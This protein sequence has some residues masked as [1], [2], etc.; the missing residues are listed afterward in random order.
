MDKMYIY[1][2]LPVSLQNMACTLEGL[3]IERQRFGREFKEKLQ[4]YKTTKNLRG[5]NLRSYQNRRLCTMIDHCY[6]TVPYYQKIFNSLGITN[7]DIRTIDDLQKLP[8]LTRE[9]VKEH[10]TELVSTAIPIRS[11]YIHSTGG[12][13]GSGLKFWTTHKEESEQWAVWWRYRND[14]GITRED[15][16]GLLNGK[17]IVPVN[18]NKPPFWRVN[19]P[20]KQVF[21]SAA[22][23]NKETVDLYV[24][25]IKDRNIRWFHGYPTLIAQFASL[26]IEKGL[27]LDFDMVTLG[28][29]NLTENQKQTIRKA[30]NVSPFQHYG[31]TEGVANFSQRLDGTIRVDE[32]FS[33]VEFIPT[34][35]G[36]SIIG[37]TF[38]NFAM[39]LLRYDTGDFAELEDNQDGGF[40]IVKSL[41]G[42]SN[43]SIIRKDGS[44][45]SSAAISLI[46]NSFSEIAQ[47]QI[48]QKQDTLLVR[49]VLI[50]DMS[51]ARKND[52][53]NKFK[54]R[55]HEDFSIEIL[56][57]DSL[58]KTKN[59]KARL[60]ILE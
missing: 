6:K 1:N 18:M 35:F 10:S 22:H 8:I 42:R 15:W 12:T 40:R 29:E 5:E 47:A 59:G 24:K 7:K 57:V 51:Q 2:K 19:K 4:E 55:T 32:D 14:L 30:F 52:L 58:E 60:V 38:T 45:V 56:E 36:T 31:L 39:P 34:E 17:V 28:S 21:F 33:Y 27:D 37:T 54:E 13:T 9:A 25:E 23:L 49:L 3:R 48:V 46:F 20:G 41:D 43:D 44:R 16:C 11:R 50:E 26:V 53:V